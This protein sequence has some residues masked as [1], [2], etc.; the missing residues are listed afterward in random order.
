MPVRLLAALLLVLVAAP[1]SA[2]HGDIHPTFRP[3]T[4]YF[5]CSGETKLH[6][7]NWA[8]GLPTSTVAYVPWDTNPPPGSVTDGNGCGGL[9]WGGYTNE[10]YDPAYRGTFKGN[11]RDM[12]VRV[13]TFLTNGARSAPTE[14]LRIYAEIDGV[15]LFPRGT[16]PDDGRTVTVTP[17]AGNSGVTDLY[18]FSITNIGFANEVRDSA[19]NVIDVETGGAALENGHGSAEHT[20]TLYIG[21]HGGVTPSDPKVGMWVW[22][23]TEVPSGITFNPS[24]LAAATVAADLPSLG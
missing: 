15:A 7:A 14:P 5:H 4:V 1:A 12:T 18:E 9:D 21:H 22:D 11:L 19:G 17:V 13:H 23:T 2:T 20:I 3:Q 10:F 16:Q 6:Q 8:A 24:S